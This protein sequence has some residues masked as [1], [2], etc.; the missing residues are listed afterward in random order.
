MHV[1]DGS[2]S[3]LDVLKYK[4]SKLPNSV[5]RDR[6][7]ELGITKF[8]LQMIYPDPKI[9]K[10]SRGR[11]FYKYEIST[12]LPLLDTELFQIEYEKSLKRRNRILESY[13]LRRQLKVA[14]PSTNEAEFNKNELKQYRKRAL[15]NWLD[16]NGKVWVDDTGEFTWSK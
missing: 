4:L 14:T 1:V 2:M 12:L 16:W 3:Q 9:I 15:E 5:T 7:N 13:E 6:I 11:I 8:L 10:N